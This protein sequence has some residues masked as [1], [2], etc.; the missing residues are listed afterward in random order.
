MDKIPLQGNIYPVSCSAYFEGSHLTKKEY[1]TRLNLFTNQPLG[2]TSPKVGIFNI[3]LDRRSSKDDN[4]GLFENLY[5]TWTVRSKLRLLVETNG[6]NEPR[7]TKQV[8]V[9]V[10]W[11]I[12]FK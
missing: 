1:R 12:R 8:C 2:V 3:W 11:I 4:R 7:K 9:C 5:G 10:Y 6:K